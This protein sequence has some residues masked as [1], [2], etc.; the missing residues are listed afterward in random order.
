M[1]RRPNSL[2]KALQQD[3]FKELANKRVNVKV[4]VK[5]IISWD[6]GKS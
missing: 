1:P 5:K 6:I 3:K 4:K 2:N